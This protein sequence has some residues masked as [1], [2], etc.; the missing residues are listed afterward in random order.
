MQPK[1]WL[2]PSLT[3]ALLLVA[4][5][6]PAAARTEIT[7]FVYGNAEN[8]VVYQ[9][10]VDLF[11]NSQDEIHV[12]LTQ[13]GGV[14]SEIF[15]TLVAAGVPPDVAMMND[16]DGIPLARAGLFKDLNEF[17]A[18]DPDFDISS[19]Y[20]STVAGMSHGGTLWALP[21]HVGTIA[22]FYNQQMF[23]ERG[24]SAPDP[25]WTWDD[26]RILTRRLSFDKDGDGIN[27]VRGA[28]VKPVV[29]RMYH[30]FW[31][32][33]VQVFSDDET[34]AFENYAGAVDVLAFLRDRVE[35]DAIVV[36]SNEAVNFAQETIAMMDEGS[37]IIAN[38]TQNAGFDIG[39]VPI[40]KGVKRAT[41]MAL[42]GNGIPIN[43]PN[44]EASW[45]FLKFISSPEMASMWVKSKGAPSPWSTEIASFIDANRSIDGVDVFLY[46]TEYAQVMPLPIS[47]QAQSSLFDQ[48]TRSALQG[49]ISP[50]EAILQIK[51]G[52]EAELRRMQTQ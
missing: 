42:D 18:K 49:K 29:A 51:A 52:Y 50:E 23:L 44:P 39:V 15:Q 19:M 6:F 13:Y 1:R 45:K 48:F 20:P 28:Q 40:R 5:V 47:R 43:A 25:D 27:D 21:A 2:L 11:N 8:I 3:A 16:I 7:W 31:Q 4:S 36:G 38:V 41:F 24:V 26:Y 33:D 10:M 9:E 34:E 14:R 22:T 37:W 32:N 12:T 35:E 46:A 17:I 30:W